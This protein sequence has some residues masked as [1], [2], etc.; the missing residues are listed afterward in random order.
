MSTSS[1]PRLILPLLAAL[2]VPVWAQAQLRWEA[3]EIKQQLALGQEQAEA[4][5]R[6]QNSGTYPITIQSTSSSCGCTTAELSRK[7]FYPGDKGEITTRFVVGDRTGVRKNTVQVRT[8]DPRNPM[9]ALV[10]TTE[11]PSL[12]TITPRL[13]RWP[14]GSKPEPQVVKI[15]LHPDAGLRLSGVQVDN[16]NFEATLKPAENGSSLHLLE[17]RPLETKRVQRAI[18]SLQ[19]DPELDHSPHFSFYAYIR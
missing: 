13:V 11:I 10:F 3:T 18:I 17:L 7:I 9:Q 14:A 1:F 12:I 4:V 8:N 2:L 16:E 15:Q 5:F 19:T 6:F